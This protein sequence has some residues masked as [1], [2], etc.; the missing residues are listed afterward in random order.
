MSRTKNM[1]HILIRMTS[2]MQ[3]T[4]LLLGMNLFVWKRWNNFLK[5][6]YMNGVER[7]SNF[8]NE[9][10]ISETKGSKH[11]KISKG[12]GGT[13]KCWQKTTKGDLFQSLSLYS[14]IFYRVSAHLDFWKPFGDSRNLIAPIDSVT[15]NQP[16]NTSGK[17]TD[18]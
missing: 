11:I 7:L 4:Y 8:L 2:S 5:Y 6:A 16:K 3:C 14:T 17:R 12:N 18:N 1:Q 13:R 10:M 9:I 15:Q